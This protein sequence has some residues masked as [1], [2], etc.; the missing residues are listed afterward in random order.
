MLLC[1]AQTGGTFFISFKFSFV[2]QIVGGGA[3]DS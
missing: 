1:A 2:G 3:H